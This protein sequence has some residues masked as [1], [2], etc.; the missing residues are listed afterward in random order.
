MNE[1]NDTVRKWKSKK[2]RRKQR[3]TGKRKN[4][5]KRN[6]TGRKWESNA[7]ADRFKDGQRERETIRNSKKKKNDDD[8]DNDN[9][10]DIKRH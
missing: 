7:L 4:W 2:I 6:K 10:E 8:N 1:R 9:Q 3:K 5:K